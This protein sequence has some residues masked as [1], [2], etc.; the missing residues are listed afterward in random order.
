MEVLDLS[1]SADGSYSGA[2]AQD[3]PDGPYSSLT[4]QKDA[5]G[6]EGRSAPTTF[7]VDTRAPVA[8]ITGPSGTTEDATPTFELSSDEDSSTF[9]CRMDA[10]SDPGFEPCTSPFTTVRLRDGDHTL[11]LRA[12]DKAGNTGAPA[13]QT[14][15]VNTLPPVVNDDTYSTDEDRPLVVPADDG[16]LKNDN[17]EEGDPLAATKLSDPQHGTVMLEADGSFEYAP[18]G[19]YN[20]NDSFTYKANDGTK[21]GARTATVTVQIRAANDAPSF[22]TGADRSVKEDSGARNI[23][24][25]ATNISPGPSDESD[26]GVS[27]TTTTDK[28]GLFSRQP[29]LSENGTLAFAPAR[30]ASGRATVKVVACD[31]GGTAN[32]GDDASDPVTFSIRVEAVNDAPV[33]RD[34]SYRVRE[35]GGLKVR[36]STGVLENDSDVDRDRLSAHKTSGPA[37][38]TLTLKADGSFVYEPKADYNGRD[39]FLYRVRDGRGGTD[40]AKVVIRVEP[41]ADRDGGGSGGTGA[42]AGG[43]RAGTGG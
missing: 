43:T 15:T 26:Q 5:A 19:D 42:D 17:D 1:R 10:T 12:T 30:N 14:F 25:W 38:G 40:V 21:D 4:V 31:T 23:T 20:G 34:D 11:D 22:D 8:S 9:E 41:R 7:T 32:G 3:L 24:S 6:N 39:A 37:H 28:K 16:V 36:A 33:A 27:F 18:D 35:D 29:S 13:S 2:P